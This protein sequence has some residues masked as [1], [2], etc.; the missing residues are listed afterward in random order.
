MPW[1][2]NIGPKIRKEFKKVNK[3]ITFTS[4]IFKASYVKTNR[5]YYLIVTLECT[6]WIVHAMADILAN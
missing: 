4:R 6:S 2:P 3:D 1:V 5:R